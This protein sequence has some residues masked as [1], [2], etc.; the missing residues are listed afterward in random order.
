[1]SSYENTATFFTIAQMAEYVAELVQR[2]IQYRARVVDFG[3]GQ[4]RFEVTTT[5]GF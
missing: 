2:G 5:G 3:H 4:T 1:M